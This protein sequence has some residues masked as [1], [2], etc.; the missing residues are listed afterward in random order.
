MRKRYVYFVQES[1]T[2][3]PVKIGV[4]VDCTRRVSEMQIGNP[5]ELFLAVRIG[6]LSSDAAYNLERD[7][8]KFF[9]SRR[10]R[11][12]WFTAKV[13]KKLNT[14][15]DFGVPQDAEVVFF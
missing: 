12:E 6:P 14:A 4:A 9:D 15:S 2:L 1:E 13:I 11:G 3:G 8:H 5:R 10:I 7:L